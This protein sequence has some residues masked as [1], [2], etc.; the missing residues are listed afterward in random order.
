MIRQQYHDRVDRF[1]FW[2]IALCCAGFVAILAFA[3]YWDH[4]IIILH[5]LQSLQY[6]L[7]VA[8]AARRNRWGYFLGIAVGG[9]WDYVTLFVN[10]FAR[11][12]FH[13]IVASLQAGVLIKP[14]QI[15]AAFG[16]VF[17]FILILACFLAYLRLQRRDATDWLRLLVSA[18]AG[19]AYFAI[20][21]AL[22]QPRYL[23]IFP[24]LLHPHIFT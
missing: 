16:F 8:L 18:A 14:D 20:I 5:A 9:L 24:R 19:L 21:V 23:T 11:S 2:V 1:L 7:I 13:A 6:V 4:T 22:S 3:A 17:H 12:G 10:N 15:I